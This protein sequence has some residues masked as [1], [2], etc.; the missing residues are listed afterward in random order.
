MLVHLCSQVALVKKNLAVS[1]R[2]IRNAD[3]LLGWGRALRGEHDN[4]LFY[5][6]LGNPMGRG[7][8]WATVDRVTKRQI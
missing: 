7:T 4:P 3:L 1:E 2:Y 8:L 6:C 5:S